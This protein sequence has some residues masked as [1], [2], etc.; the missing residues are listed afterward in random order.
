[1]PAPLVPLLLLGL[2]A[3]GLGW[4]A[5]S[6]RPGT[7]PSASA[8]DLAQRVADKG[9]NGEWVFK[10]EFADSIV[11]GL[12]SQSY[13]YLDPNTRDTVKIAPDPTGKPIPSGSTAFAWAKNMNGKM[14]ILAPLYMATTTPQDKF[15]RA[16]AAGSEAEVTGPETGY[17]VLL[18][19]G[20]IAASV[21]PPGH[22]P[23]GGSVTPIGPTPPGPGPGPSP[24]G[25]PK[26]GI[27]P[28]DPAWRARIKAQL[29]DLILNGKDPDYM[30][31]VANFAERYGFTDEARRLRL[32]AAELRAQ[33]V[34]PSPPPLPI[35]PIGPTPGPGPG[36]APPLPWVPPP[37][38]DIIPPPVLQPLF[39]IVTTSDPPP[40]GDLKIRSGPGTSYSQTGGAAKNSTVAVLNWN[41]DGNNQW[42]QITSTQGGAGGW[43]PGT[44]YVMQQYLRA[45]AQPP[46]PNMPDI[47]PFPTP[48]E[49]GPFPPDVTPT[50]QQAQVTTSSPPPDGDLKIRSG[51]STSASQ[52]AGA[53][54]DSIVDV[55][56]WN[57]ATADGYTW[58]KITSHSGGAGGWSPGTGYAAQQFLTLQ[59]TTQGWHSRSADWHGGSQPYVVGSWHA[60]AADWHGGS[61]PYVV[62]GQH[63]RSGPYVAVGDHGIHDHQHRL[64]GH[65]G[66]D[67]QHKRYPHPDVA[68]FR[69][70]S[71]RPAFSNHRPLRV[72]GIGNVV[73]AQPGQVATVVSSSGVRMRDA[74]GAHGSVLTLIPAGTQVMFFKIAP[75][76]KKAD[77]RAPGPPGWALVEYID[78][79]QGGRHY[80]GWVQSEWLALN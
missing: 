58:A 18:Y 22:P 23:G 12:S 40:M 78:P 21:A 8:E 47:L 69:H 72:A 24:I 66:Y 6:K 46:I 13:Q 68:G 2:G 15:L 50:L 65:S 10:P 38:P 35:I 57:S 28:E 25:P 44:G 29:E 49:P 45:T 20:T 75:G 53:A 73:N 67:H 32:R 11:R 55:L 54:K 33:Q 77:P 42:S 61:Q 63:A 48:P 4:A 5:L 76:T 70:P 34:H 64:H 41:A 74:A 43:G 36:P 27:S 62:G 9:P 17:A 79:T 59:P 14:S 26:G 3:V 56:E 19:A 71:H 37:V 16:V 1:M 7:A 52:V 31:A 30:E 80:T 60:K 51:P 39:A